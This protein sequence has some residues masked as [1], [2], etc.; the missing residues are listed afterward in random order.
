LASDGGAI[1]A[2]A[3]AA[4]G[5]VSVA[6]FVPVVP[7]VP[8]SALA[9]VLLCDFFLLFF[10]AGCSPAGAVLE[11]A[12]AAGVAGAAGAWA[13]ASAVALAK[14]PPIIKATIRFI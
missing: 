8:V 4:A 7:V 9:V 2:A 12:V 5:F 3:G 6:P 11:G 13:T 1:G 10:L 14:I